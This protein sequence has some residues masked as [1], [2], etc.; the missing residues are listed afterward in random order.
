MAAVP[1]HE[2]ADAP[3]VHPMPTRIFTLRPLIAMSST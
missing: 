3:S 1:E 2:E